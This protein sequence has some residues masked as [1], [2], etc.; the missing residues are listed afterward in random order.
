MNSLP[1]Q[2]IDSLP[3]SKLKEAYQQVGLVCA[4]VSKGATAGASR[5]LLGAHQVRMAVRSDGGMT[6]RYLE[7][8]RVG[9]VDTAGL[10]SGG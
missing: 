2:H 10:P 6:D 7:V 5:R 8:T 4:F 3:N 9:G 1:E